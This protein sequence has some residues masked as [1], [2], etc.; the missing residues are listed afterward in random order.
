MTAP[1][2][3]WDA[4]ICIVIAWTT[5]RNRSPWPGVVEVI[6]D[7]H[8]CVWLRAGAVQDIDRAR[9]HLATLT[10]ARAD[11]YTFPASEPDPLGRARALVVR[12]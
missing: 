4:G 2:Q 5:V 10:H 3:V 12:S 9:A 7:V 1:E 8:A 6:E 11:V